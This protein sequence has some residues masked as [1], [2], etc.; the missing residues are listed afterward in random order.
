[1]VHDREN[2]DRMQPGLG[3][4]PMRSGAWKPSWPEGKRF[5]FTIVDDTDESTEENARPVYDFLSELGL[6]TTKT[7]WP[8]APQGPSYAG[9]RCLED[10]EYRRWIMDLR[11][12]GFEIA[13]HGVSD[14][15]STR[16]RILRGLD[17]FREVMGEDPRLHANHMGQAESIYWGAARLD[18]LPSA[19]Y[20]W[21]WRLTKGEMVFHG[22]REGDAHFWGDLCHDRIKYVRN[23]VFRDINT[24]RMDPL[25]PCHDKRRPYVRYWFSSSEGADVSSFCHSSRRPIRIACWSKRGPASPIL[26]SRM[27]SGGITNWI[28]NSPV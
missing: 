8:L 13:L 27:V 23:F 1:M 16:G 26:T 18:N 10:P 6:R 22:H 14:E 11:D 3:D 5:A 24:L 15:T 4:I 20:R 28:R 7:I 2:T 9:G 25:M 21:A 12:R 17:Y 19:I